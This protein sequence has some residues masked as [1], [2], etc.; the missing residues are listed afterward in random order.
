MLGDCRSIKTIA[1]TAT[2]SRGNL[3]LGMS[4]FY[5]LR[6]AYGSMIVFSADFPSRDSVRI[7]A[8]VSFN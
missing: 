8:W 4:T 3:I 5:G 2:R 6:N 7:T 1:P